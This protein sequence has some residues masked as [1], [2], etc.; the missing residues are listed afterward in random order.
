VPGC[1]I[2]PPATS[3][4]TLAVSAAMTVDE[5]WI[6]NCVPGNYTFTFTNTLSATALHVTDPNAGNNTAMTMLTVTVDTDGDGIPDD[7]ENACG[8]N[9]NNGLSIP[10]RVDGVYAGV[11]DD[12]DTQID[13]ALPGGAANFDCDRDG[14]RGTVEAHV[15]SPSTQGDQDPCGTN[16]NPPTSPPTPIG[17]PADLQGG[18]IPDSSNRINILD[19]TSFIAPIRYMNTNLGAHTGDR[20]WDLVPGAGLFA[21]AINIADL[22]NLIVVT[23]PMLHGPRAIN[24]PACPFPP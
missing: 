8:S 18:G 22:S 11:D 23:P 19:I 1:T 6:V 16:N 4:H 7:V 15:Y 9:P 14:Y 3:N 10:E 12:L 5:V 20:R 2:T 13:E 17:W 24:G 21:T